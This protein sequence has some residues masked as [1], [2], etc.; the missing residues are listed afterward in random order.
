MNT[1]INECAKN[2]SVISNLAKKRDLKSLF[3][4][5]SLL[6]PEK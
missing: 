3:S 4:D 6:L 5:N 1:K 2:D